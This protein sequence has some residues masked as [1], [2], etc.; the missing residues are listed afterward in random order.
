MRNKKLFVSLILILISISVFSQQ[1]I[2]K[3]KITIPSKEY[4]AIEL[5]Q[6]IQQSS[7]ISFSYK[8]KLLQDNVTYKVSSMQLYEVLQKITSNKDIDF[9]VIN[10]VVVIKSKKEIQKIIKKTKASNPKAE[11]EYIEKEQVA[12]P[13]PVVETQVIS[14]SVRNT[15]SGELVLGAT[16][17]ID[18]LHIQVTANEFG[19]FSCVVPKGKHTLRIVNKGHVTK[20]VEINTENSTEIQIDLL[21]KSIELESQKGLLLEQEIELHNSIAFNSTIIEHVK[22]VK[23]SLT[24]PMRDLQKMPGIQQVGDLSSAFS[25]RGGTTDQNMVIFDDAPIFNP[26]HLFGLYS[27]FIPYS[28]KDITIYKGDAP[29]QFGG[30]LSSVIDIRSK[31]GNENKFGFYTEL[32][33]IASTISLESPIVKNHVSV[34]LNLRKSNLKWLAKSDSGNE[35][36]EFSDGNFKINFHS[37]KH[38]F[39]YSLYSGSDVFNEAGFENGQYGIK[40]KNTAHSIRWNYVITPKLFSNVTFYSSE[41]NYY[42]Y[43]NSNDVNY[44]NS[45][46]ATGGAKVDFMFYSNNKNSSRFG[47]DA[48]GYQF[49]PGNLQLTNQTLASSYPTVSTGT[50]GILALYYSHEKI[51]SNDS[52]LTYGIRVPMSSNTGPATQFVFNSSYE[53]IDT[54]HYL[55]NETYN[56]TFQIEPRIQYT[57][58]LSPY[59]NSR[60]TYTRMHQFI[61]CI[62]NSESQITSLDVWLP[63]SEIIKP[64]IA[65]QLATGI[66]Y[67]PIKAG[68][69]FSGD[70]YIKTM[71]NQ[72]SYADHARMLLNPLLEGELRFGRVFATGSEL[73]I[74]KKGDKLS[75]WLSYTYMYTHL[76]KSGEIYST[77]YNRPHDISIGLNYL[78]SKHFVVESQWNYISGKPITTPTGFYEF[79]GAMVPIYTNYLNDRL[80]AYHKLDLNIQ[81]YLFKNDNSKFKHIF[82]LS[83]QNVYARKNPFSVT[84]NKIEDKSGFVIPTDVSKDIEYITTMLYPAT[85]IPSI[86][87]AIKFN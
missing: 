52:K 72:V 12:A 10:G 61:N 42:L 19:F 51:F 55:A 21:D 14:G 11:I 39:Y 32:G 49:N 65:R 24:D 71:K 8:T 83:I 1:E 2:L 79:Q 78:V 48:S 33:P 87:Y 54:I 64:Q 35:L 6:Q 77:I 81:W 18:S 16:I 26:T 67:N 75:S 68:L 69:H 29:A 59:V 7:G 46:I 50:I 44:W 9:V 20:N 84:F 76:R 5:L 17:S 53:V 30:K 15:F 28:L 13:K 3:K 45:R 86:T 80:P 62:S 82:T 40:W 56:K 36:Y 66:V 57:Y 74:T 70:V 43:I 4:T 47:L 58:P 34:I 25:V 63:S 27:I 31:D 85:I 41:Y 60:I 73:L 37:K 38:R 22:P 23:F